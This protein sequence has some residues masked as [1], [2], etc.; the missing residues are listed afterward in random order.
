MIKKITLKNYVMF[1]KNLSRINF[2]VELNVIMVLNVSHLCYVVLNGRR[3]LCDYTLLSDI[4]ST[5]M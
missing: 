3:T 5:S 1:R 4:P 2:G